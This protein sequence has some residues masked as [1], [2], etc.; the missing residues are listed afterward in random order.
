[1]INLDSFFFLSKLWSSIWCYSLVNDAISDLTDQT[2]LFKQLTL[3]IL[4]RIIIS[5][6]KSSVPSDLNECLCVCVRERVLSRCFEENKT[7]IR[8]RRW[9][10]SGFDLRNR[11]KCRDKRRLRGHRDMFI[12]WFQYLA[13]L[14]RLLNIGIKLIGP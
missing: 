2:Y 1:M 10:K 13:C 12:N 7:A 11:N 3:D 6:A 9:L 8:L 4:F 14:F 5:R